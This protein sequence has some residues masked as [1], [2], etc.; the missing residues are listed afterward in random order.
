MV[1]SIHI[2]KD[3]SEIVHYNN[4]NIPFYI[5]KRRLTQYENME[6][7]CH[8]HEDVEY[9][10]SYQGYMT[11]NINGEKLHIR[12]GDAL[13]VNSRQIHYGYSED[14][15][16]CSFL[17]VVFRLQLITT[18]QELL[19]KYVYPITQ[20]S[21]LPYL[22]LHGDCAREAEIIRL[23]DELYDSYSRKESGYELLTI[24]KLPMLWYALFQVVKEHL[25]TYEKIADQDLP[26]QRN[27]VS[28][29]HHQ[30]TRK[31]SLEEIAEAG[32]VCRSK[33]CQIFRKYLNKTPVE[34]LN[35]YRLEVS[36]RYL[37]DTSMGITEI[38]L[39][40]GF[41]SSSYYAEMFQKYKGCTPTQYRQNL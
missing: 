23:F 2:L 30:Y 15:T 10:R 34:F 24:G 40:C 26:A 4:P 41:Q 12:E 3:D 19:E 6:G 1:N 33:C 21:Q 37:T 14:K 28:F 8:W 29:I 25:F 16:D 9:I 32:N 38:A 17:C 39:A 18:N 22:Y 36:M 20:N 7:L 11:Y 27:M 5:R 31:L 13:F 35:A